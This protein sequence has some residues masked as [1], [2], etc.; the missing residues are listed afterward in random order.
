MTIVGCN[1]EDRP[2]LDFF[3][4]VSSQN[5]IGFVSSSGIEHVGP[6]SAVCAAMPGLIELLPENFEIHER[7]TIWLPFLDDSVVY[8]LLMYISAGTVYCSKKEVSCDIKKLKL[9][10]PNPNLS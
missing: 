6:L 9:S 8:K 7:S 10:K 3:T 4:E 5:T 1:P 2:Q